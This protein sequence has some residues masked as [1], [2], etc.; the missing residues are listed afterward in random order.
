MGVTSSTAAT[1]QFE[2]KIYQQAKQNYHE[3]CEARINKQINM[4]L[5]ASYVYLSMSFY[6]SRDDVAFPG[7]AKYFKKNSD[8]EREHAQKF[9]EY[10]NNRGG[11]IVLQDVGKPAQDEWGSPVEAI[12][13]AL[14]LEKTV[15]QSILDLHASG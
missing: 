13:A 7:F 1:T 11:R 10:Q 12:E 8:E 9:M 6:F 2:V 5:Y 4:E 3:D 15:N 14:E